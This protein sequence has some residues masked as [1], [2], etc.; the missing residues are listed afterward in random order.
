MSQ[1]QGWQIVYY[2]S[3]GSEQPRFYPDVVAQQ[4][5]LVVKNLLV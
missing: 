2:V 5:E 4:W 3:I 1:D